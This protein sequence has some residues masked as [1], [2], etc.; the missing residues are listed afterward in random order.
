MLLWKCLTSRASLPLFTVSLLAYNCI[1]FGKSFGSTVDTLENCRIAFKWSD[2]TY[3][4]NLR[5]VRVRPTSTGI[6]TLT[7]QFDPATIYGTSLFLLS[8]R[9]WLK[10][11][12]SP[13]RIHALVVETRP[14]LQSKASFLICQAG[15][16]FCFAQQLHSILQ[17]QSM[18]LR[19]LSRNQI[20]IIYNPVYVCAQQLRSLRKKYHYVHMTSLAMTSHCI[21][22]MIYYRATVAR[23]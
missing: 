7:V 5:G 14:R 17:L 18:S 11:T 13:F 16:F 8:Q 21:S 2:T 3:K 19:P 12:L 15:C 22:P 6:L 9:M 1:E 23:T 10:A 4:T 20:F